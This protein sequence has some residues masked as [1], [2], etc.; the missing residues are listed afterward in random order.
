M[1]SVAEKR[2]TPEEY[3][4]QERAAETK[5]E[6][7][8]G[9]V[10]AMSGASAR[11]NLIVA[12][13]IRA[14][15]NRLPDRC[16]VY[17]SDMRVRIQ[18]PT[19]YYYPDVSVVCG[20]AIYAEDQR[21]VLVNPIVIFEI[22][23]EST[24]ALDRGRKFLSYQAIESLQEYVLVSQEEALIEHYRRD[25]NQWLYSVARGLETTLPLPAAGCELSLR[26][27]YHQTDLA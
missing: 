14:L 21:D 17:P 3:L 1:S 12:G 18:R 25:D 4:R 2:L 15:G 23:S 13:L 11:H 24:M 19:R 16:R 22:L 6:Y 5:S 26:E 7:D 9:F 8:D 27:I 20:E 10:Y